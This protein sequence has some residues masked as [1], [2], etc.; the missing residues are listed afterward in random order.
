MDRT[1]LCLLQLR[2]VELIQAAEATSLDL[3][4][5]FQCDGAVQD[6]TF[7]LGGGNRHTIQPQ[8]QDISKNVNYHAPIIMP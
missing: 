7:N 2:G 3:F 5:P 4:F 8:L 6:V 1:N